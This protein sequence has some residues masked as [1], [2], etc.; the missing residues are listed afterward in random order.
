MPDLE[1]SPVLP[2]REGESKTGTTTTGDPPKRRGR[3]PGSKNKPKVDTAQLTTE[4]N[5][6]LSEFI[7]LP[8]SFVSPI[9]AA[10]FEERQDRTIRAIVTIAAK[11]PRFAAALATFLEGSAYFDLIGT[12]V[13]MGIG[14]A[15]DHGQV[16]ADSFAATIFHIDDI[17]M[18]IY[19]DTVPSENG[20]GANLARERGLLGDIGNG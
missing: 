10:V 13:G 2:P 8:I 14:F 4:L 17:V 20:N 11:N 3:P 15:V 12:I 19:P 5:D 9:A 6:K 18:R 7:S 1:E 16:E